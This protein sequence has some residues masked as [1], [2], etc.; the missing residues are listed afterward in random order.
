ML[1]AL[2]KIVRPEVQSTSDSFEGILTMSDIR[3]VL[4]AVAPSKKAPPS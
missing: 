3:G 2:A 4:E 1:S